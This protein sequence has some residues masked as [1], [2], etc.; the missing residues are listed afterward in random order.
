MSNSRI[1]LQAL[2]SQRVQLLNIGN[3]VRVLLAGNDEH[4]G[5]AE[6]RDGLEHLKAHTDRLSGLV[7]GIILEI[8]RQQVETE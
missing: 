4:I 3:N 8:Q 6:L 1:Q 7:N 5:S 2:Y